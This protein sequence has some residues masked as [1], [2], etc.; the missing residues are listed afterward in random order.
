MGD[1]NLIPQEIKLKEEK[2][3]K[4]R[5]YLVLVI[6][7]VIIVAVITI[8]PT[9][10]V[11]LSNQKNKS[12]QADIS[13]LSYV[14]EELNKLSQTK[15]TMQDKMTLIQAFS[16]IENKWTDV[17]RDISSLMPVEISVT[18]MNA[19]EGKI[20]MECTSPNHQAI[21]VFIA[22]LESSDK[23]TVDKVREIIPD[24]KAGN[25]IFS[26]SFDLNKTESKVK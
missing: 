10:L 2:E 3:N 1:L 25:Y 4:K 23:F 13:K 21:A 8:I 20:L 15:K 26:L 17:I 18:N 22:N 11:Y 6:V 12:I 7:L 24:S 14:T 9:G 16:L 19:Q 5:K